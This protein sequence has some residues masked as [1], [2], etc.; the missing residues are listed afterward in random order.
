MA[1]AVAI[2]RSFAIS[3]FSDCAR[4]TL[5]LITS[6]FAT[7]PAWNRASVFFRKSSAKASP[8]GQILAMALGHEQGVVRLRGLGRGLI[9][10]LRQGELGRA[11]V[12]GR[13]V[14]G[15]AQ[16][17]WKGNGEAEADVLAGGGL[18]LQEALLLFEGRLERRIGQRL[19]LGDARS[20]LRHLLP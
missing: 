14:A 16:L 15:E 2:A 9:D 10:E 5:A 4:S 13:H 20:R 3:A 6:S 7:V 19:G 12:R 18:G 1:R 8:V 11:E 17:R